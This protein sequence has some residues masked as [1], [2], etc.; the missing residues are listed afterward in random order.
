MDSHARGRF[1]AFIFILALICV[2]CS[3]YF[4]LQGH[5][6]CDYSAGSGDP[7]SLEANNNPGPSPT[8]PVPEDLEDDWD[9]LWGD[10]GPD[11]T[12]TEPADTL[13]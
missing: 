2:L 4:A 6:E 5:N 10:D 11:S 7:D 3:C 9:L 13:P 1:W 12:G 8:P